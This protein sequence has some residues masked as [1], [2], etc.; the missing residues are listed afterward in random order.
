MQPRKIRLLLVAYYFPPM[1]NGGVQRPFQVSQ[2]LPRFGIE[3]SVLTH[4]HSRTDLHSEPWVLRVYD[5][6]SVG[7][8]KL[9]HIPIRLLQRLSRLLGKSTSWHGLWTRAVKRRSDAIFEIA[10]PDMVLATYPP[11]E[12]LELGLHFAEKYNV[13]LIADFRDGL[14]FEPIE[15]EMLRSRNT[16]SRYQ[17][18]EEKTARRAA[19]IVTVSDP[20]SNYFKSKYHHSAVVTIPNGYDPD[21]VWTEPSPGELD[22]TKFNVVYTGR[23]GLSERGRHATAFLD[24][25]TL[26]IKNVPEVADR[27]RIHYVGQ[28]SAREKATLARLI[29]LGIVCHHGFLERPRTIGFQRAATLLLLVAATSRTSVATGKLFEYLNSGRPILGLTRGTAAEKII[30]ETQSG[31]VVNPDDV[32]A[33]YQMLERLVLDPRVIGSLSPCVN[34]IEKYSRPHQLEVLASFLKGFAP[35]I[36]AG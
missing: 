32:D 3:V 19:G 5:T 15:A 24:A 6:N 4:S 2:L 21:E 10:Q 11:V 23:L 25:V 34:E 36:A 8:D 30:I 29:E 14:L 13:P 33:V 17:K 1:N 20:I 26:L 31:F 18:I 7:V 35:P 28:F 27:L 16:A 12:T 9:L 22:R